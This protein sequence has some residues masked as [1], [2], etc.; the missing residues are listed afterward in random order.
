[1]LFRSLLAVI[2]GSFTESILRAVATPPDILPDATAY[3]RIILWS[4]PVMFLFML[5]TSI[6]R[7]VG[8]TRTPFL[9]LVLS[10][11]IGLIVTPALIRGWFGLPQLGVRSAAV[12]GVIGFTTTLIWLGFYLNAKRHPLAPD[13]LLL[14]HMRID[15]RLLRLL[16][17]IGIPTGIQFILIS[18][19]EIAVLSFV[20]SFG[21]QATAAYGAVNQVAS[22][23]QLPAMSIGI[24]ASVFGAQAIGRGHAERLG[25]IT[26]TAIALH[27][28]IT[29]ML[30]IGA[31]T[32]SRSVIT[33]FIESP[34]VVDIAQTLLHITLWSYLLFGLSAI[35]GGVM[36]SSGSVLWPT[37]ISI[38]SI[39]AIEVP[40][41]YGLMKWIGL[42]GIWIAYPVAFATSLALQ[43]GYYRLIW[44]KKQHRRLI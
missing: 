3:A 11:A 1:M 7:G 42:D 13:R 27:L 40:V 33:L 29:G 5:S 21:S 44:R 10:T 6:T 18:L 12:A 39:W 32:F 38:F 34:P 16:L 30:V 20:N 35:L 28:A 26:R 2:G 17:K 24:A 19:S 22:Y 23:V 31:Y 36:R 25:A 37:A 15:W 14:S 8:D 9:G 4:L 41:A 43:T